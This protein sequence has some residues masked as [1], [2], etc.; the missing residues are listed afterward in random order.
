MGQRLTVSEPKLRFI[1]LD[2]M[3]HRRP[4]LEFP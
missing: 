1:K 2:Q 4:N 3:T